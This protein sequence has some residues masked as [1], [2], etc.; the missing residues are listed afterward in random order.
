MPVS[1]FS[2]YVASLSF[3]EQTAENSNWRVELLFIMFVC[4]TATLRMSNLPAP[5]RL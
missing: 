5:T 1:V 3:I 2:R 4:L